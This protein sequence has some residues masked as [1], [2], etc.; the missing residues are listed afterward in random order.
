M[1]NKLVIEF[2][3]ENEKCDLDIMQP[4]LAKLIHSVVAKNLLVT[5]DNMKIETENTEFDVEEFTE[6]FIGVY[7]EFTEE[8]KKFFENIQNEINTYYSNE[9]LSEAIVNKIKSE[10]D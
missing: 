1:E 9:D 6:I 5:K 2:L 10:V 3:I 7:E 4:D 8:I